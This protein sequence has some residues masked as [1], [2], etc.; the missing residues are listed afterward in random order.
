MGCL[1]GFDSIAAEMKDADLAALAEKIGRVEGMPVVTD[2][3]VIKPAAFL[4]EVLTKR[5]PNP[6]IPDTPQRI[7]TDTSQKLG[8]RFGE[9]IRSY[10][11][12]SKLDTKNLR[13]T[14]LVIAAWCRYLMGLDDE[15]RPFAPS[16]D[17]LLAGLQKELAGISLGDPASAK[18]K[19]QVVLSNEKIF[20]INLYGVGLGERIE[21]YLAELLE[22]KGAVRK[23]LHKYIGEVV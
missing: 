10:A 15:G 17:P 12:S 6:A 8:I 3:G 16:P 18:G 13:L 4:T 14:P 22:G 2:P 20:G 19:L 1:L 23:T 9:T 11:E 7:A 5:L 21:G